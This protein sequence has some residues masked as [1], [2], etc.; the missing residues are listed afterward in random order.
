MPD[1]TP[2]DDGA[3]RSYAWPAWTLLSLPILCLAKVTTY[4]HIAA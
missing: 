2:D 3:L 4:I 1:V